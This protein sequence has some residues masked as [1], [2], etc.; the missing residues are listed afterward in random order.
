MRLRNWTPFVALAPHRYV[1]NSDQFATLDLESWSDEYTWEQD[2][3]NGLLDFATPPEKT[4]ASKYGDCEDYALVAASH[5]YSN[6]TEVS[7][8]FVFSSSALAHVVAHTDETIYSSGTIINA[9]MDEYIEQSK[10]DWYV[11]RKV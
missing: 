1:K 4:V 7:L 5:L 8:A 6:N 2:E 11:S 9:T 10:Y 3:W